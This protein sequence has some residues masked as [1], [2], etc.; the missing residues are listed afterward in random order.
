MLLEQ[1]TGVPVVG[2]VPYLEDLALPEE[3]AASLVSRQTPAACVEIAVVRLPHLANFDEFAQLAAEPD[4][5]VRYVTRPDEL[6]A[7]DLGHPGSRRC[8][9]SK[10]G[11]TVLFRPTGSSPGHTSTVSSNASN[12]AKPSCAPWLLRAAMRGSLSQCKA[13]TTSTIA[14]PTSSK[15]NC[16]SINFTLPTR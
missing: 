12:P 5:A 16:A 7:P 3:D 14:W 13:A 2:V 15:P 9:I 4:V 1:R 8:S 10:M 11:Q 6:R